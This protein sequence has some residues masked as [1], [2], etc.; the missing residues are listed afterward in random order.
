MKAFVA[1]LIVA[2]LLFAALP[3][4]EACPPVGIGQ[5]SF[6]TFGVQQFAPVH[7]FAFQQQAFVSPF[8]FVGHNR[9]RVVIQQNRAFGGS[10]VIIQQNRGLFRRNNVIIVR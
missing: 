10:R 3:A 6:S 1:C 7:P 4:A 8:A 2:C 9:S 5:S